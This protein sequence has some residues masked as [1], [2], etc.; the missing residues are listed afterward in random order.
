MAGRAIQEAEMEIGMKSG[1]WPLDSFLNRNVYTQLSLPRS[2]QV[3]ESKNEC[4]I[5]ILIVR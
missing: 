2:L 1:C 4:Q 3:D 5:F